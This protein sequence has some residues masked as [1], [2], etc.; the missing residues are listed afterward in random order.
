MSVAMSGLTDAKAMEGRLCSTT[1]KRRV[2]IVTF[3]F[4]PRRTSAVYRMVGL[5]RSLPQL[6][7]QPTVLT[8][9]SLM[10]T[11]EPELL[12][13]L[14]PEVH[15]ERTHY[16]QMSGWEN[17]AASAVR[18]AGALQTRP[19]DRRQTPFDRC[20]R[21][22]GKTLRSALYFPDDTVGW[23]PFALTRAI[24]LLSRHKFDLVY[25]T[26]PP[27][28]APVIGLLLKHIYGL[29]WASEFMDP[30]Y[31]AEGWLRRRADYWLQTLL[32]HEAD[33]IVVM[34]EGHANE[35][36]QTFHLPPEKL[37]V[38]RNGFFEED[39]IPPEGVQQYF[40]E[41]GFVHFAH[42]GTIYPENEG[43]FFPALNDLMSREP[44]LRRRVR[45]HIVGAAS[46]QVL[47]DVQQE[48]LR[49]IVQIHGLV[50]QTEA[51]RMMRACN[52]LLLFWGR[53]DFSR[54]AVAGKTYDYLRAGRPI[55]AITSEGGVKQLI[56]KAEAGWSVLPNDTEAI[57]T[58]LL[59]AIENH[60]DTRR[61]QQR[62]PEFVAQFRWDR[63]AEVLARTFREALGHGS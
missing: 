19:D 29:P 37:S 7:W 26:T 56:E 2:L 52:C 24:R 34:V 39:F 49:D 3:D 58:V 4:P 35:L 40:W 45:V 51:I 36:K 8:I 57:Q 55:L 38:V 31:P 27:R 42:F 17:A 43:R 33:R 14:P 62:K 53:P 61:P 46:E 22:V 18:T 59:Q 11:L 20:L 44:S 10:G 30:W 54:L 13:K 23:I 5:A 21:L 12:K 6:G 63:Q 50:P 41:P 47:R 32:M 60:A 28:A 25:T 16:L 48:G 15:I 1:Q 9:E